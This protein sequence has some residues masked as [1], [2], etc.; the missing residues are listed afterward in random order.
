MLQGLGLSLVVVGLPA[1]ERQRLAVIGNRLVA[2][3]FELEGA[4]AI[5][6]GAGK[7]WIDADRLVEIGEGKI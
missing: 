1:L 6:I 3:A 5:G 7:L 2:V 4:P